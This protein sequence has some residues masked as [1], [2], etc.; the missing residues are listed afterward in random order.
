[1]LDIRE[2]KQFKTIDGDFR[3][4]S[5]TEDG[6]RPVWNDTDGVIDWTDDNVLALVA[7]ESGTDR[8]EFTLKDG[9]KLYLSL[10]S[11]AWLNSVTSAVTS[12]FGRTGAVVATSG[13]YTAAQV[14][15]AFNKAVDTLDNVI[16][17]AT[18]VHLTAAKLAEIILN[19]A[20]RHSH[21]NK[22]VLDLI[23]D[24]GGGVIP[25]AT[26]I[27]NWDGGFD[28]TEE[29]VQ[30]TVAAFLQDIT[31]L[32]WTYD[33]T[34]GTLTPV[35]TLAAFTT[36][37]LTEGSFNKYASSSTIKGV[38]SIDL[39]SASTVAG[40]IALAVEGT[41]Y[42]TGWVLTA[43]EGDLIIT[44]GLNR[45][46]A[47]VSVFSKNLLIS[48]QLFGN[49][50]YSGIYQNYLSVYNNVVIESLATIETDITIKLVFE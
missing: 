41:D 26:Q 33:D 43:D 10:G 25:T 9:S 20:A 15:N 49:A 38:F 28:V 36:D 39:P 3:S 29:F 12:A 14:T 2:I 21:T 6:K 18:N 1:M 35:V 11:L 19:T 27:S 34:N 47:N 24:A 32:T 5:A 46:I 40:R 30:D 16:T 4:P 50:A 8:V 17:G 7:R 42:P 23:T 31:G 44:H 37:N 13:D 48:R 45:Q 22:S